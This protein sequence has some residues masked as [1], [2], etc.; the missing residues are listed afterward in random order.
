[1]HN[2]ASQQEEQGL[3]LGPYS[4]AGPVDKP[5]PLR[6]PLRGD[7]AHIGLAGRYLVPHYV[8]PSQAMVGDCGANLRAGPSDESEIIH[9]LSPGQRFDLLDSA[10]QWAWGCL[11]LEGPV[12][13]VRLSEL[14]DPFA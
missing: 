14:E 10:G 9:D 8:V 6:T 2:S 1:M 3:P 5:D 12:G 13:Y 4:L 11:G 7:L